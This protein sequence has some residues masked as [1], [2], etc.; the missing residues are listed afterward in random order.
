LLALTP[1]LTKAQPEPRGQVADEFQPV[2]VISSLKQ[3]KPIANLGEGPKKENSGIV[4]SRT[5]K[6]V[7]WMQNDSGDGPRI[8]PVDIKGYVYGSDRYNG[9]TGVEIAGALNID[10]EDIAVDASGNVLVADFGNNSNS[11]RDLSIYVIPEPR[12]E[13]GRAQ[14]INRWFFQYPD[15][16]S[17]PPSNEDFNYDSEGM[18]TIGDEVYIV[19]KNRSDTY[20]KLYHLGNPKPNV[21]NTLVYQGRFNTRGKSTGADAT[22]DGLKLVISTYDTVW[23]F[24]RESHSVP[25]FA[26]KISYYKFDA[27]QVEAICFDD[28]ETL[29]LADEQ[30][31]VLYRLETKDFKPYPDSSKKGT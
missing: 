23:L 10:W 28:P 11:R 29:I 15:Q 6:D 31:A 1:S 25:F 5:Q 4:K 2:P 21:I 18:F 17:H 30:S 8:Y 24:E 3:L 27:P 19:S 12:K 20:S 7:Y 16:M 13:A 26:G 9:I 22:P 14:F